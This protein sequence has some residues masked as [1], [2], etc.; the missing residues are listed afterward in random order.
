MLFPCALS[1]PSPSS[2]P[3]SS[4]PKTPFLKPE[5]VLHPTSLQKKPYTSTLHERRNTATMQFTLLTFASLLAFAIAQDTIASE[6]AKLPSCAVTCLQTAVTAANCGQT[7]YACQ[8]GSGH[9]AITRQATPCI[10]GACSAS[11]ALSTSLHS[12][13]SPSYSSSYLLT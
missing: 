11:D 5:S 10:A 13:P 2:P 1:P 7:D 9:D 12:L 3:I 8:C 4:S 6:I